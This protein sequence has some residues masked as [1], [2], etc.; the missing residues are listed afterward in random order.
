MTTILLHILN[1][2]PGGCNVIDKIQCEN[3]YGYDINKYL[4]S[5]WLYLQNGGSLLDEVPR[6]LYNEVRS[7]Y[8]SGC[9][10]DWYV[11]NIGFLASYNILFDASL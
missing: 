4:I 1:H 7:N 6:E 9:Y 10:E 5:L 2:F 3:R 11:G 8:Q